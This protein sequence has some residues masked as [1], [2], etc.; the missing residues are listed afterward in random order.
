MGPELPFRPGGTEGRGS[1]ARVSLPAGLRPGGNAPPPRP[2]PLGAGG[3]ERGTWS[4]DRKG[5]GRR[6]WVGRPGRE[7][8]TRPDAPS[9]STSL[10]RAALQRPRPLPGV[11]GAPGLDRRRKALH[12][13]EAPTQR[14]PI[15]GV[16][17]GELKNTCG[18]TPA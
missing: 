12:G 1:P 16:I 2:G 3:A 5:A 8:E 14:F 7:P 18:Q 15:M 6:L 11:L 9:R 4:G 10:C 17:A 13:P